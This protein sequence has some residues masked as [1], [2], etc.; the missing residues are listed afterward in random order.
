M[1]TFRRGPGAHSLPDG[2][3]EDVITRALDEHLGEVPNARILRAPLGAEDAVDALTTMV[4][5]ATRLALESA[6][7]LA[8]A[9]RYLGAVAR[10]D[11][12]GERPIRI[13]WRLVEAD[14]PADL[15]QLSRAAVA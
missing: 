15:L 13:T 8:V 5:Q 12:E 14:L 10:V 9:C 1:S 7:G 6:R 2:L 4:A 11:D 3:Y